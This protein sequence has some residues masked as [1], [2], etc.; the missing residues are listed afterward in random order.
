MLCAGNPNEYCGAG[1]RL[2]LYKKKAIEQSSSSSITASETV[3]LSS[4]TSASP[5]PTGPIINP[6]NDNY[7]YLAC[8]TEATTGRAL[9]AKTIAADDMT[10]EKCLDACALYRYAGIEYRRECW[11]GNSFGA[12]SVPVANSQ[13]SLTCA[14]NVFN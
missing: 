7:T 4:T 8:Y 6:G 1:S 11:C 5:T 12:G 9:N 2:S 14:G 13:C 10:V 3:T